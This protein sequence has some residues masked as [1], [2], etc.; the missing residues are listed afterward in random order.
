MRFGLYVVTEANN[1]KEYNRINYK[2]SDRH[3]VFMGFRRDADGISR[4]FY[5]EQDK[6]S[7]CQIGDEFKIYFGEG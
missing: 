4:R 3:V 2:D 6:K 7:G 5:A 1:L